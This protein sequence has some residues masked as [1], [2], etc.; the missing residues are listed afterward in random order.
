MAFPSPQAVTPYTGPFGKA[1]LLHLLRRTLFGVSPA[2][3]KAFEG[4]SLEEVVDHLLDIPILPPP[5][6]IRAYQGRNE[7]VF[8]TGVP[9][10]TTWV[11]SKPIAGE[12][13]PN[14]ARRGSYKQWWVQLMAQQERNLREKLVLFWHNHLVTDT[15]EAVDLA[16]LAYRYNVLLRQ[17]CTGN[18]RKLMYDITLDG[19]MLRYLN[20]EKNTAGA[21]DENYARELQELFCL[22]K[23]PDSQYTEDDVKAAARVLTGWNINYADN[24]Q[25]VFR[26]NRH[27]K[28]DKS[29]SSFYNNKVIKGKA[30]AG[31]GTE[32][33]NELLDM[34]FAHPETARFLCRK[35]FTFFGY[36]EINGE[37]EQQLI[38][39]LAELFRTSG[40][41]LKPMLRALFTS[42]WFFKT[43]YR[44]AMIKSPADFTLGMAR[45]M[46]ISWPVEEN[47]FEARYFFASQLFLQ[48]YNQGQELGDPPNVAG[49]PAYY[50]TPS[51]HELWVDT[52]TYPKRLATV[53]SLVVRGISTGSGTQWVHAESKN[54]SFRADPFLFVKQLNQPHDPNVLIDQLVELFYGVSVSQAVKD[55]LKTTYLLKGQSTDFYWSAAYVAYAD[56]PN[57]TNPEAR[58]VPRQLQDLFA[59]MFTAAEY[60][61][62]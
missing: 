56:N 23:G 62:H 44:G 49:W 43:E 13:N 12:Q 6:P 36:Y 40:Y 37:V 27:D 32:E 53:D 28:N 30:T 3:L 47:A 60:H 54:K 10:G 22:G 25:S 14:G 61:L 11:N 29:F 58:Q 41:E 42:E 51:F 39:P 46:G 18:F 26:P 16:V 5:P 34:I 2:D 24:Y 9:L 55:S 21:P 17:S 38:Q 7:S 50:Q 4:Q 35:F 33:I 1:E 59:Y 15:N 45:Q 57:T 8:D 19:A 31:A 20:G 52:A 48:M